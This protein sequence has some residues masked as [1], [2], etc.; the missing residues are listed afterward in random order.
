[1]TEPPWTWAVMAS[2]S[3]DAPE[4]SETRKPFPNPPAD[5]SPVIPLGFFGGKVVFAMPEGEI[6]EELASKL[7]G[8]LKTDIYACA[9]GAS[10]L[11]YW[12]DSEDKL[13]R[14][15]AVMWFVRK[16]REAGYYDKGRPVRSLGVWPDAGGGV[17]LHKGDAIWRWSAEGVL[18]RQTI[19]EAMRADRSGP[20]YKLRPPAPQPGEA[21]SCADGA[22][23]RAQLDLWRFEAIGDEGLT[24]ADVAL[25]WM[26]GALLGAV[27]PF[28]GHLLAHA[29]A[30][31]GK[32]TL[33]GF[34]HG[35]LSALAG[36]IVD[37]FTAAGLRSALADMARP[38]LL[39]EAESAPGAL[40]GGVVEQALELIRRMS[41]GAG[42][43][44]KQGDMGGGAV[45]QTAVGAVMLA[46]INPPRLGPADATRIVEIRLGPLSGSDLAE[47]APRPRVATDA[48]LTAGLAR[49]RELAPGLLGR[50]LAQA[51]RYRADVA[52]MKAALGRAGESPRAADLVA[53]LAAGR[54]LLLFDEAL[55]EAAADGEA[56]FWRP[57]LAQREAS[58]VV[59]NVGSDAFSWLMNADSGQHS[60]DRRLTLGEIV[61]RWIKHEREREDVLKAHGLKIWED[62]D[63][64][65][66][67]LMVANHHPA[68]EKV[69]R[70]TA[71]QDWRRSL[72]FLDALGPEYRTRAAKKQRFGL[73]VEQRALAIPLTPLLAKA[74]RPVPPRSD[75]VPEQDVDF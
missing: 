32:S 59:S 6:R 17:V 31:S 21:A 68:L 48:E 22:W 44:R 63:S 5:E 34:I 39:D 54:R 37:S 7:A 71:W 61:T 24:G 19:F 42:G 8:M 60:G 47:D 16:C 4:V 66:P 33:V 14:D 70:G 75:A 25:G 72:S 40:G 49:A 58:E 74:E 13:M 23:I 1:M 38:V 52:A 53:M 69:F 35:L 28:R 36:D 50:A 30:G 73:G 57:L 65:A 64:K 18:T 56:A 12:R 10:F 67:W 3:E 26:G 11:A 51:G 9:A 43:T 20:L 29:L 15:L 46:A 55:D 62:P 27:A 45:T 41:T 2:D